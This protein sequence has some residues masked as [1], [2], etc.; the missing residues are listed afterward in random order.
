MHRLYAVDQVSQLGAL[1]FLEVSHLDFVGLA[2]KSICNG[3]F[4]CLQIDLRLDVFLEFLTH[5][6]GERPVLFEALVVSHH[7]VHFTKVQMLL[8]NLQQLRL[9][10]QE[11]R[12]HV[13]REHFVHAVQ[14]VL[15]LLELL[16]VLLFEFVF[17]V[18]VS[19]T[20]LLLYHNVA[21]L[22]LLVV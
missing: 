2:M 6:K 15:H 10:P 11:L 13:L 18:S 9:R 4:V 1:I 22:D 19:G 8:L 12:L 17:S 7:L 3:R 21:L 16:H 14:L 5:F 20:I